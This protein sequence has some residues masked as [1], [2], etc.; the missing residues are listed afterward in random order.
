[1]LLTVRNLSKSYTI[2]TVLNNIS[3]VINTYDRVGLVGT[4]GVG[5]SVLLKLL[6]G[7]E[8]VDYGTISY[9][10]SVEIGYLPQATPKFYGRTIDDLI[11]ESVGNLRQLEERMRQLE[12]AMTTSVETELSTLLEQ[13]SDISTKFQ[14]RGGY[15]LDHRIDVVLVGLGLSHLPRTRYV[16]TLSGG[17]KARIGLATLLLRSADLL[18]LDE[19]TNHLD[20]ASMEWLETYLLHHKGA[21]LYASHDRQFLNRTSKQ[22]FEIDE[23]THELKKYAGNY[24]AYKLTK[25]TEMVKWKE[26]YEWQQEKIKELKHSIKGTAR[27]VGGHHRS[28]KDNE[29]YDYTARGERAEQA[30]SRAVKAAEEQ[31]KRLE[32]NLIPRPPDP[33]HIN[34]HFDSKP[35]FAST[36]IN[37]VHLSKKFDNRDVLRNISFEVASDSHIVILG[38]NGAGKST[39]LKIIADLEEPD[40][41]NVYITSVARIS[42][43]PQEANFPD[44]TKTALEAYSYD[45]DGSEE[46]FVASLLRYGLFSYN[47]LFKPIGQLSIGQRRKL[48]IARLI[49]VSPNILLLDEPTNHISLDVLEA[50]EAAVAHFPGPVIAVSHDR[51]FI[52]HFKSEVW[53]LS[54][55]SLVKGAKP[56]WSAE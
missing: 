24:D 43:L 22:I 10:S 33:L 27:T 8:K 35:L 23:Y 31:L 53:E 41:G 44:L 5:K 47:D 51:W 12:V 3:F 40:D 36:A 49:A 9:A 28:R 7:Q 37:A 39:L 34:P 4:N 26:E 30:V 42:Y 14:E 1:M 29:K 20:F 19:P 56:K 2:N 54:N 16:D 38:P 17:E 50:F 15:E 6:V 52:Q 11:L 18:L 25:E 13:Y 55:G 45:L 46:E 32:V 21:V 48:E